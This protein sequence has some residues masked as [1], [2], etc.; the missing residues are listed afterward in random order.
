MFHIK[1]RWWI[2]YNDIDRLESPLPIL[3]IGDGYL[4]ILSAIDLIKPV[5][6]DA[7]YYLQSV[8]IR[9][10]P[11]RHPT[12]CAIWNSGSIAGIQFFPEL[13]V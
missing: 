8:P 4:L 11:L 1:R 13:S 6:S 2:L 9:Q 3:I 12:N 10:K 7:I 5:C